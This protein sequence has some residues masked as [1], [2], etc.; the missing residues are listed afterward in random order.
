MIPSQQHMPLTLW[1]ALALALLWPALLAAQPYDYGDLPATYGTLAVDF[2]SRHT[3]VDGFSLGSALDV[4]PDGVPSIFADGDDTDAEGDDEDGILFLSAGL[5]PCRTD[6]VRIFLTNTAG[7]PTAY[8]DLWIDFNGN[9]VFDVDNE[10]VTDPTDVEASL[11]LTPGMN[12]Y[13][14]AIPCE[15]KPGASYSRAR[16]SSI[17]SLAVAGDAPDGEVEDYPVTVLGL[18]YGDAPDDGPGDPLYRTRRINNGPSHALRPGGPVLGTETDAEPDGN[19]NSGSVGDDDA[20]E[21]GDDE[22][23]IAPLIL[24]HGTTQS[25]VQATTATGGQLDAFID[26]DGNLQ[27]DLPAERITPANGAPLLAGPANTLCFNHPSALPVNMFARFRISTQGGLPPTGYADDGEVED[28]VVDTSLPVELTDFTFEVDGQMGFLRWTTLSEDQNAG[29]EIE[30]SWNTQPF[31][32]LG[33]IEGAV[34]SREPITYHYAIP[35]IEPGRHQFRLKQIDLDGTSS[36]SPVIES[37]LDVPDAYSLSAPYP[38]PFQ[39]T[40][41]VSMAVPERAQV[42]VTLYDMGGRKL[43]TVFEG[44]AHPGPATTLNVDDTDLPYGSYLLQ[45]QSNAFSTSRILIHAPA[46]Q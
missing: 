24:V 43:R 16:L 14:F 35:T 19:P 2:G 26:F 9:G 18:D 30:H 39:E 32:T 22:D 1:C 10:R 7:L 44:T 42:T 36:Y 23:G 21:S 28:Y 4:D 15:A 17:G 11:L 33:F 12:T 37:H 25:C 5:V 34:H 29:F 20:G 45:M 13:T 3:V 40:A 8:L 6:S 31:Q 46:A 27:F 38:N 41:R